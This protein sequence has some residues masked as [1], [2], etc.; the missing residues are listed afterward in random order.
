MEEFRQLVQAQVQES[1]TLADF[2][3]TVSN[4]NAD[5]Q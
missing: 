1:I 5:L 4:L 3:T 2:N